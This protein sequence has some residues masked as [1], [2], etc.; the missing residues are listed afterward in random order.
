MQNSYIYEGNPK[1]LGQKDW[2]FM[3]HLN[4]QPNLFLLIITML[5]HIFPSYLCIAKVVIVFDDVREAYEQLKI[6]V[7]G[8]TADIFMVILQMP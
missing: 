2:L 4:F 6:S 5:P 3:F 8:F 1:N 7:Q